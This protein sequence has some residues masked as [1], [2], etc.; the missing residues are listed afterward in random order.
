MELATSK[1]ELEVAAKAL[2]LALGGDGMLHRS[3]RSLVFVSVT[4]LMPTI[5]YDSANG[6]NEVP[7]SIPIP[8]TIPTPRNT[9][10]IPIPIPV[11]V[12]YVSPP[13][14]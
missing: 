14:L 13:L 11:P 6:A 2:S 12:P 3:K 9:N 1:Y 10:P 5:P 7:T 8:M 4:T